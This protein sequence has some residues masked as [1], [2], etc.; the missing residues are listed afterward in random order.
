[1]EK[2]GLSA[3]QLFGVEVMGGEG[4]EAGFGVAGW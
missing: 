3:R 4:V 2:A 1:M